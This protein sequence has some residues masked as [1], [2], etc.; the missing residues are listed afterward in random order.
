MKRIFLILILSIFLLSAFF[1]NS[2]CV[3]ERGV[4]DGKGKE[5]GYIDERESQLE[6]EI[7]SGKLEQSKIE[8]AIYDG[9]N[10]KR[11]QAGFGNLEL[12]E[13]YSAV[14]REISEKTMIEGKGP[15]EAKIYAMVSEAD[16]RYRKLC[17]GMHLYIVYRVTE[18]REAYSLTEQKISDKVLE[19]WADQE[20]EDFLLYK[21]WFKAE[22]CQ[23]PKRV[24]IGA[25]CDEIKN[26]CVVTGILL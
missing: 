1:V 14:A 6:R 25:V 4:S 15:S 24:G 5:K 9:L 19:K 11:K 3:L 13:R 17:M 23:W 7:V 12:D 21:K 22:A 10:F 8:V 26:K 2:G 16:L 20:F 18:I